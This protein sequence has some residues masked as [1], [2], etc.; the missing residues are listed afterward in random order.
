MPTLSPAVA[1]AFRLL[2]THLNLHLDEAEFLA[3]RWAE[4]SE[5]DA[6]TAR[7]LISELV[8]LTR[9]L[10]HPHDV[11]ADGDCASCASAWPCAVV[12]TIHDFVTDPEHR[13]D[14]LV[15]NANIQPAR[16]DRAA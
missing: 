11:G 14:T 2:R 5:D 13:F 10:L 9:R 6:T 8:L 4:W 16:P 3:S 1:D 12:T 15:A 7:E